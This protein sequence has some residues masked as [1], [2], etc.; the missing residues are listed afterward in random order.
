MLQQKRMLRLA[1]RRARG[2]CTR[3]VSDVSHQPATAQVLCVRSLLVTASSSVWKRSNRAQNHRPRDKSCS[4]DTPHFV[5]GT[6]A[7]PRHPYRVLVLCSYVV[8]FP[9]LSTT[10]PRVSPAQVA[11]CDTLKA[12]LTGLLEYV[13]ANHKTGLEW[14]PKG[15]DCAAF[16]GGGGATPAPPAGEM[17]GWQMG[18]AY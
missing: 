7:Y 11:F 13:Q 5:E 14:N 1:G 3:A 15:G 17:R 16:L 10:P 8:T 9:S 2:L 12:L 18:E 6:P 4:Q